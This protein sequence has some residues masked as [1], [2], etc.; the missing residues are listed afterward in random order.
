[1]RITLTWTVG[2]HVLLEA[3]RMAPTIKRVIN[4]STDEVYGESSLGAAE[5]KVLLSDIQLA[6]TYRVA[7]YHE[8]LLRLKSQA[9]LCR[10]EGNCHTGTHKSILGSKSWGRNDGQSLHD[11]LQ[12]AS[13]YYKRQQCES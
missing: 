12:A 4:V 9:C 8:P 11:L 7:F 2:T 5:G 10:A 3:C 13:H 6:A 1:M